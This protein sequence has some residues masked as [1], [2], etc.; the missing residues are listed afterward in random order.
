MTEPKLEILR[1]PP[2]NLLDRA[3]LFLDFDGTLVGIEQRPG[4]VVVGEALKKL[5]A[6]LSR[7]VDGRL[8]IISGRPAAEV[9]AMFGGATFVI[10]GSHGLE[11]RWPNGNTLAVPPPPDLSEVE[12]DMEQLK[13]RHPKLLVESKPFGVA[14]HYRLA[15]EAEDDCKALASAL[16]LRTG[17]QLQA[18]KMVL[19]LKASW[20]DKGSA[21]SF[22][23]AGSEMSMTRPVFLGDDETDETGFEAAARL[24]GAGVL[25]GPARPTAAA[26]G[27]PDV[28]SALHWLEA[29]SEDRS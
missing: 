24:G 4:D 22:L 25:V 15:P 10:A 29:A 1:P 20:A 12:N 7:K 14:L 3:S 16:Q 11:L 17:L 23:M 5:L 21:L 27:L 2:L 6:R 8:A 19:E 26:F 28:D 13:K 18:G 9:D